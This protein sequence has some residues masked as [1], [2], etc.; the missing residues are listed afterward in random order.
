MLLRFVP[1]KVFTH[2]Y[3]TVSKM[4]ALVTDYC[5]QVALAGLFQTN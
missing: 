2:H 3:A 5:H 1:R 4:Q